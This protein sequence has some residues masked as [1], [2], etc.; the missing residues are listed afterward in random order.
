[1]HKILVCV[2]EPRSRR[3]SEDRRLRFDLHANEADRSRPQKSDD[4]IRLTQEYVVVVIPSPSPGVRK[5]SIYW[6]QYGSEKNACLQANVD[7]H[8]RLIPV[9]SSVEHVHDAY[10]RR[11]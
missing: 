11:W 6:I 7:K 5:L 9:D 1:M 3:E 10:R 4:M 8:G 2:I